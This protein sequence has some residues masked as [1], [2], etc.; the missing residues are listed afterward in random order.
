MTM[1]LRIR[2]TLVFSL[3]MALVLAGVGWFA[4]AR[5][6]TGLSRALDQ[7]LRAG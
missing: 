6:A 2:L 7:Q 1:P 3:A 4:Y 5:I